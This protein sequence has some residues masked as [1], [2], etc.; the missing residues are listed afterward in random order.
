M[1]LPKKIAEVTWLADMTFD[2]QLGN[3]H[4]VLDTAP[5][6]GHDR[7]PSPMSLA[8]AALAGCTAMDIVSILKKGRQPLTGLN[9]RAEGERAEEHPHR[10][11]R[12][13]LVYEV[14][15]QGVDEKAVE[16][17][18]ALSEEKY[19]SVSATFKEHTEI[20]TRY[21]LMPGPGDEGHV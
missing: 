20:A 7:G 2:V 16:R 11:V 19:C 4:L 17:A 14:Y 15:G 12:V 3:H 5:P 18:I 6:S 10:Y 8:L 1:S 13:T 9:V 21:E